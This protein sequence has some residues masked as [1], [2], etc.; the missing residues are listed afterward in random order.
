MNVTVTP[1]PV[2]EKE[3][4]PLVQQTSYWARV[5]QQQG[6]ESRVFDISMVEQSYSNTHSDNCHHA[7]DDL[8]IILRPINTKMLMAYVPY[9]P[10]LLPEQEDRGTFLEELSETLRPFLPSNCL[11]IRYDLA[12]QSPWSEDYSRKDNNTFDGPPEPRV[13]EM[14]MNFATKNYNLRKAPTDILPT[15]TIFMDLKKDKEILLKRMKPKTRYNIHL[16]HRRGVSVREVDYNNL[17]VWYDLYRE[18]A[19]RN[20]IHLPDIGYFRTVL[21]TRANDSQSPARVHL[22]LAEESG[23]AL[24]GMFLVISGKRATYLYGA[25]STRK[26]NLMPAYAL[27]WEAIEKA[28]QFGCVEYDMFGIS[29]TPDPA[30]PMSGLYR[31]KSGFGGEIFHRQGCWDYPLNEPL[32][33]NYRA[34]EANSPGFYQA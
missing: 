8:L 26:R 31:F 23:N 4:T 6:C 9:G 32:Y 10:N 25:S 18:T 7:D 20:H 3:A 19:Q 2:T 15:N 11:L 17:G 24:A 16:A 27:Q 13:Q 30:H 28:K 29:P 1:K 12:W 33:E 22:L 21:N 14:R 34:A 5:K